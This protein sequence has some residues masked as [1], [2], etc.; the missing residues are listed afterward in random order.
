MRAATFAAV[1]ST[2]AA[3]PL[4]ARDFTLNV[5][6][7]CDL[8]TDCFIQQYVDHDPSRAAM[9]FRC[10]TLSYDTH[11]G[12]DFALRSLEQMRRGVNV[13][14]AAPGTVQGTRDGMEDRLFRTG[15]SNRIEG[16]EC[17]NGVR[18]DHGDGWS[19]QYCHLKRGSVTVKTGDRVN[20]GAV[21]GEVGLSGRTQFPHVH[22][23]L[24]KDGRVIDPFDPDGNVQCGAPSTDTLWQ[25][26]PQYRPGAVLEVGFSDR[27]PKFDDVKAGSA[28]AVNMPG[29]APAI[30]VFGYAFGGKAGD[31]MH[32]R[33]DGPDGTLID[34]V[35]EIDRNQAQFFRALGKKRTSQRWPSGRYTGTVVL[36][37]GQQEI[38]RVQGSTIVQ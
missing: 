37:R 30:V 16:R 19:T 15:Q 38:S 17:G 28:A 36:R 2:L 26:P 27:V 18:I 29:D 33:I 21:L 10:S 13:I 7:D 9:D 6:I 35:V 34:D 8:G 12:T 32:L 3:T 22:M 23:T 4:A 31:N 24:R 1:I 14:A 20:A 5:P 11:Q 25:T